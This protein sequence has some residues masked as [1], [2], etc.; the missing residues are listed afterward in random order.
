MNAAGETWDIVIPFE[1]SRLVKEAKA[2]AMR[3]L[4]STDIGG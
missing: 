4:T 2:R 1:E 3:R